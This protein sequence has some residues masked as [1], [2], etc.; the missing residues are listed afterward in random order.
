MTKGR[1]LFSLLMALCMVLSV[2]GIAAFAAD[3]VLKPEAGQNAEILEPT[4]D[5]VKDF[6][7]KY[8][9]SVQDF[10]KFVGS[11]VGLIVTG[12]KSDNLAEAIVNAAENGVI[13][14]DISK[15]TD[16][17]VK[18]MLD[19]IYWVYAD[20]PGVITRTV[21]C[22]KMY[23]N[24]VDASIH[25]GQDGPNLGVM[26]VKLATYYSNWLKEHCVPE[27]TTAAPTEAPTVPVVTLPVENPP[28]GE[29]VAISAIALVTVAAGAAFVL[30]RKKEK[31]D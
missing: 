4:A 20:N 26:Q 22:I 14:G 5:A 30:T 29:S 3:D 2:T 13:I 1:K 12:A 8:F 19:Q 10:A 28:T 24:Y 11:T 18:T 23:V 31:K 9:G 16:A 21:D 17:E 27:T 25:K 6:A 15:M 7:E